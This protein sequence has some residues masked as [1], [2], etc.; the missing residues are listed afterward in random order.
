MYLYMT[1]TDG[2]VVVVV[3]VVITGLRYDFSSLTFSSRIGDVVHCLSHLI[4][5]Y[6]CHG[7]EGHRPASCLETMVKSNK[8]FY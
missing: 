4:P 8:S 2:V 1:S 5:R 6:L 7:T 3:V